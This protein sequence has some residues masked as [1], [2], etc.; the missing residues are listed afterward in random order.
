[1]TKNE[2]DN[3][4]KQLDD[5]PKVAS[6]VSPYGGINVNELM[7]ALKSFDNIPSYDNLLKEF[8]KVKA[9][10]EFIYNYLIGKFNST[11]DT[12]YLDILTEI[13]DIIK[14]VESK[15]TILEKE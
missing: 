12:I 13:K 5:L 2:I 1:M 3:L 10:E 7:R 4:R 8:N 15:D 11:Q 14:K 9:R 6:T